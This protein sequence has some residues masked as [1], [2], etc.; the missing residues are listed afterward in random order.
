MKKIFTTLALAAVT[1]VQACWFTTENYNGNYI[2]GVNANVL[3]YNPTNAF[4]SARYINNVTASLPIT[5]YIKLGPRAQDTP[6][7]QVAKLQYKVKHNGTWG[8]WV[9]VK[10]YN[11]PTSWTLGNTKATAIFGKENI[12]P[13]GLVTNDE[14][15]IRLYLSDGVFQ[16]GDLNTDISNV[17]NED[18]SQTGSY[19]G[20]WTAPF[21]FKVK[22]NGQYW[23]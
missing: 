13:K 12:N 7:I 23:R 15:M 22:F 9:T 20:G 17:G 21:V 5:V 2:Q 11:N 19:E 3:H 4:S 10:T 18:T 14:I 16:T 1:L 6:N 8:K